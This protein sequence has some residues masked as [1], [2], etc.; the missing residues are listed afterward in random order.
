MKK[1]S[2]TI[3]LALY[4]GI[5]QYLPI[6]YSKPLGGVSSKLRLWACR[7]IFEYCGDDVTIERKAY[8]GKGDRIR[9]GNHSGLGENCI[10]PNGSHIGDNVMMGPGCY[11]LQ[12][13]HKFDRTDIP[14]R[15]QGYEE[16]MP[17]TIE[18]DCW[19]GINVM[20]MAGRKIS[21]GSIIA[22]GCVL[23]KDFPEYSIVGGNP[24]KLIRSRK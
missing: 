5:F 12:Q 19:I 10:I 4:Y 22:A 24:G 14:M 17:V 23:T 21:K 16:S 15:E 6:S 8:F 13:N 18:D 11:F 20:V 7:H 9:I 2:K 1:I 3:F